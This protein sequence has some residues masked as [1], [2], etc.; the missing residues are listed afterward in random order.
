GPKTLLAFHGIGQTGAGCFRPFGVLLGG[1]FTV[2]A[3]D[4]PF[5]GE[6]RTHFDQK[7]WLT[8]DAPILPV[9]WREYLSSFL[10]TQNI[11]KFSV[12][13]F[14]LGGR[15]ALATM[16]LFPERI[17]KAFLIAPDGLVDQPVYR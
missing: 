11:G 15:F 5:H 17:E 9:E 8:G 4:L 2:Y 6:S 1:H 7:R 10:Q 3:F 16:G 12:A 14:S 13:G